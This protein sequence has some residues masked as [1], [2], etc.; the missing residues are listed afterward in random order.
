[1]DVGNLYVLP[2]V[3]DRL[4]IERIRGN[5][6]QQQ[7]QVDSYKFT[8]FTKFCGIAEIIVDLMNDSTSDIFG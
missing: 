3:T 4:F 5:T 7:I 2:S 8:L 6:C 1:M